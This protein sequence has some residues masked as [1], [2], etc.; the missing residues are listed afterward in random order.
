M[1]E[2]GVKRLILKNR[3]DLNEEEKAKLDSYLQ[4]SQRLRQAYELKEE[5]RNIFERVRTVEEGKSRIV[6][7]LNKG[8]QIYSDAIKTIRNHL[9]GICQYF[10]NRS[11]QRRLGAVTS[12]VME[13]INKR[14]KVIKRQGYGFAN[15]ANFRA[16]L[17]PA[18]W[19]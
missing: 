3:Q 11:R 13:G 14:I 2:K 1:K 5:I 15:I 18:F 6:R 10:A 17:L 19:P 16:R 9:E 8:R 7:W 4:Q 12:G